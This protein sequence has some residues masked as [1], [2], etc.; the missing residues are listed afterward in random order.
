[1]TYDNIK[2]HKKTGRILSEENKSLEK[3]RVVQI[4]PP[5]FLGLMARTIGDILLKDGGIVTG[6]FIGDIKYFKT[7]EG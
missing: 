7:I 2:S 4:N 3:P 5:T 1:M 6:W